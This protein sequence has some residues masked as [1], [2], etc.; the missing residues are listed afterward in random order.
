MYGYTRIKAEIEILKLLL[1]YS[2]TVTSPKLINY[3]CNHRLR[4]YV[5][6]VY[7]KVQGVS[8][9]VKCHHPPKPKLTFGKGPTSGC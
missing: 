5:Q 4:I 9:P 1:I 8:L 7:I 3:G 2:W 6:S